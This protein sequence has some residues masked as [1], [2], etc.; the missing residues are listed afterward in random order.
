[1]DFAFPVLTFPDS[2]K[3]WKGWREVTL[4]RNQWVKTDE[5]ARQDT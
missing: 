1:M 5:A 4:E 3:E 2:A